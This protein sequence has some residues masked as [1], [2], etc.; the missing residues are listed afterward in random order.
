MRSIHSFVLRRSSSDRAA[1]AAAADCCP[2]G[3]PSSGIWPQAVLWERMQAGWAQD[4]GGDGKAVAAARRRS[5]PGSTGAVAATHPC[6]CKSGQRASGANGLGWC[7][8]FAERP[9]GEQPGGGESAGRD[10]STKT[11]P[12]NA[13]QAELT[14]GVTRRRWWRRRPGGRRSSRRRGHPR[15]QHAPPYATANPPYDHSMSPRQQG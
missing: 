14:R 4:G 10:K 6:D 5:R 8:H 7:W 9:S 13:P 11:A 2:A 12:K 3:W 1:A 15:R